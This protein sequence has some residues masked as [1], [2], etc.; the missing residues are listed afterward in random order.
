M[1]DITD[2]SAPRFLANVPDDKD[3]LMAMTQA[4]F[5]GSNGLVVRHGDVN[6]LHIS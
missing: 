1:G 2:P 4:D 5:I 6:L 3:L